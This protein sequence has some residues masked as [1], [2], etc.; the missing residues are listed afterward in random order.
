[1]LDKCL[2]IVALLVFGLQE[3]KEPGILTLDSALRIGLSNNPIV[4]QA[5]AQH[6]SAQANLQAQRAPLNPTIGFAV[7]G[8]GFAP[9]R[10]QDPANYNISATVE[11]SGRQ[12]LRTRQA[13][14]QLLQADSDASTTLLSLRQTIT[15]AY[16]GLQAATVTQAIEEQTYMASERFAALTE[17][18][19]S[20]GAVPQT[21]A[22]RARIALQ[23]EAQNRKLTEQATRTAQATLNNALGRS[24]EHA[25]EPIEPLLETLSLPLPTRDELIERALRRR[26]EIHSAEATE[27]ALHEMALL[28]RSQRIPDLAIG[29]GF[30]SGPL[31][32]GVTLP[33]D[34]GSIKG[35]T[36]KA[37]ADLRAQKAL[38]ESLYQQVRLEVVSAAFAMER[39]TVQV[40]LYKGQ[41]LSDAS[42]L[43]RRTEAGYAAG[44]STILEVL[45]AQNTLRAAQLGYIVALADQHQALAN[46]ERA[47][48]GSLN[49]QE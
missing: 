48:G 41:L 3:P 21:N 6:Q 38:T 26:P 15:T 1:M 28:S 23:Q 17:K 11:I 16:I 18:Q 25:I 2:P 34:L 45:D 14:A 8:N 44:G 29:R 47:V 24:T 7:L 37:E 10:L 5:S 31:Q 46:L 22:I 4:R 32:F 39:A 43:V 42:D 35:S 49:S 20:L 40:A 13:S 33:L 9:L 30:N 36:S 12:K 19:A 27:S